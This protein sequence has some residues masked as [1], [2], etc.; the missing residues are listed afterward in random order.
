MFPSHNPSSNEQGQYGL[1][2][3]ANQQQV[4]ADSVEQQPNQGLIGADWN[5]LNQSVTS[6]LEELDVP[7]AIS[8]PPHLDDR[9][10][11]ASR[12]MDIRLDDE[13]ERF[14]QS[15][16]ARG[17][18]LPPPLEGR[19]LYN[20]L[21]AFHEGLTE[22]DQILHR[23]QQ[24]Q[25]MNMASSSAGGQD[26]SATVLE[27]L[28]KLNVNGNSVQHGAGGHMQSASSYPNL[29]SLHAQQGV[30]QPLPQSEGGLPSRMGASTPPPRF[31]HPEGQ[32]DGM[33]PVGDVHSRQH[34]MQHMGGSLEYHAAYQ[35]AYQA[36]LQQ[37]QQL[38]ASIPGMDYGA[39]PLIAGLN[40]NHTALAAAQMAAL[41]P[42]ILQSNQAAAAAAAAAMAAMSN[43]AA[44]RGK[45]GPGYA[46]AQDMRRSN[47]SQGNNYREDRNRNRSKVRDEPRRSKSSGGRQLGGSG[48]LGPLG[49]EADGQAYKY[50]NL[51]EVKGKVAEVAQ[52]QAGCRF[53]QKK[54]DEG[55][56]A[57]ID[58]VF[59]EIQENILQL[60]KDPF[61]NYLIQKLLDRCSEE[62][63]LQVL[64]AA[65]V[66]GGLAS[67]SLN[68]HGT[69]A[70]QKLIETLTTREQIEL[71]V[72]A[73]STNVVDLI[74][75]LNGNHVIQ[76]CLQRLGPSEAQFIYDAASEDCLNI[77][78]HRHGCCVLQRCIDFSTNQQRKAII[79]KISV[80]S[81]PLSQDPFGNYVVQYI[82]ELGHA[83][84]SM[85]VMKQ[86]TG[87]YALLS[88]QKFSSNVV[89]KC[90][91]LGGSGL[92]K[93]REEVVK[94]LLQSPNLGQLL[95]DPYGNYVIQSALNVSSGDVH[96]DLIDAIRPHL[97]AL[98]GT[99]HGKRILA[100]IAVKI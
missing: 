60:M 20:D 64:Q 13:Y 32:L 54:F 80:H 34:H 48:V 18:K 51:S 27:A 69:R 98:R 39:N 74:R 16:I 65:T 96:A 70:V 73:L 66:D 85:L 28:T 7:R 75:D 35:A 68:T 53:L 88:T 9:W 31:G 72:D 49:D 97:P 33:P 91:K 76:R 4:G 93:A 26:A 84:S 50:E 2:G 46:D 78:T 22:L 36:A 81:L 94:E 45:R 55:G 15:Q 61:G 25:Q 47:R 99:P 10:D 17:K 77:A 67:A 95:Q 44:M 71:V 57:A 3:N 90:L 12:L 87:H 79:E 8:A 82:L 40:Q 100:K 52:D 24:Q 92:N 56:A 58:V 86:L 14:Y 42:A 19:T 63:R 43:Q 11:N 21:P 41:N 38:Y 23:Q 30:N 89:E 37:Q 29:S 5:E 1:E 6:F 83:E 62:Q 59:E